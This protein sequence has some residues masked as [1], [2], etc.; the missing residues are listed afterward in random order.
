MNAQGAM[1]GR[2]DGILFLVLIFSFWHLVCLF[3]FVSML[4]IVCFFFF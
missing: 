4:F 3:V 1:G 2:T